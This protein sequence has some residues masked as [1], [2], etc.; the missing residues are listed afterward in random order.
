MTISSAKAINPALYRNPGFDPV[1]D[2]VPIALVGT[3]PNVV[4]VNPAFPAKT[5]EA[6]IDAVKAAPGKHP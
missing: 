3:V 4:V 2:S 1:K 5:L 6:L